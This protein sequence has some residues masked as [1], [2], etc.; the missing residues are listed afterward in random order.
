MRILLLSLLVFILPAHALPEEER[1]Y[2]G[3]ALL[4]LGAA[5]EKKK[6]P[7]VSSNKKRITVT[8]K[9]DKWFAVVG[10]SILHQQKSITIDIK[11]PDG[12]EEQKT[13]DIAAKKYGESYLTIK[14][15]RKVNP[16][17]RDWDRIARENSLIGKAKRYWL[18]SEPDF[19][20]RLPS[21]GL[22]SSLYG[23]KRYLNGTPKKPHRG[24]DIAA[25]TGT[26][27]Y[28]PSN[29][30]IIETGD[31]FFTGNTI[32]IAHGGSLVS[33]YSH[34]SRIDVKKGARVRKGDLIGAIGATGRVTG[35]HLHWSVGL[36]GVWVNP[37]YF[38]APEDRPIPD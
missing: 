34:L 31:F 32:L 30:L 4:D 2:G 26:P 8:A 28:A 22:Y 3:V 10:L 18:D 1:V 13:F 20:F 5:T 16:P 12:T 33:L 35:P 36:N 24:L 25:P 7:Y 21:E 17:K 37:I 11:W 19:A 38:L 23:L 29:G 6:P 14:N 9:N 27:V 15:K